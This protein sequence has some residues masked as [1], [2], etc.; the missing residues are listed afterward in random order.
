MS[1]EQLKQE[2]IKDPPYNEIVYDVAKKLKGN[3]RKD[4]SCEDMELL[5]LSKVIEKAWDGFTTEEKEE[6]LRS[7]GGKGKP[8]YSVFATAMHTA[9]RNSGFIPYKL[10][11]IIINA[12]SKK[13][14]G[15]G[16]R[17]ATNAAAMKILAGTLS[18]SVNILLWGWLVVDIA[19]P[20]FRVTVPCVVITALSRQRQQAESRI[21]ICSKCGNE[22]RHN[23]T[24]ILPT[25]WN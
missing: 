19:S 15:H 10:T 5:I 13:V 14:L 22:M 25:M 6:F 3:P 23:R 4:M 12:I 9:I 7:V 8:T 1:A 21:V 18:R 11:L 17:L 20:A 16:L 2:N 24:S